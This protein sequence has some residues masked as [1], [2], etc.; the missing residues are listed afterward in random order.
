[1]ISARQPIVAHRLIAK[2]AQ[3][4]AGELYER[5]MGDNL[6]YELWRNQ[7]PGLGSAA[8]ERKFVRVNAEKCLE[9]ARA[10]LSGLLLSPGLDEKVKD[11]IVEALSLD[12]TLP[13]R[14]P[15]ADAERIIKP[16]ELM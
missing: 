10:T 8:L 15:R 12:R 3:A 14:M 11:E 13:G 4:L 6:M 7:N 1:M 9:V 5:L 2:T 16:G